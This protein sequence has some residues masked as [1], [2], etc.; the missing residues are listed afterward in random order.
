M[1]HALGDE[2]ERFARTAKIG[3]AH[4]FVVGQHHRYAKRL[5]YAKC[6]FEGVDDTLGFVA[7]MG[8]IHAL[9]VR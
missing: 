1:L 4:E 3:A 7:Q 9:I 2:R 5:A 6:F 8:A